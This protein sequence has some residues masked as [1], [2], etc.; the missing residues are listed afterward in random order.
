MSNQQDIIAELVN[1]L[2]D[3]S[4]ANE[5]EK[6]YGEEHLAQLRDACENFLKKESFEVGQIVKWKKNL[7]N[8][9]LPHQNQPAIVVR[10]LEE[11]IVSS[12]DESGSPY[13]LEK[14]DIV[15]GV[16]S[17]RGTFLVFYYDSSRFESY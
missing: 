7:N 14:L 1:S 15:L 10:L 17:D 6:S 4:S 3:K 11:P 8:R 2:R 9:K 13:F 12:D 5:E 16:M